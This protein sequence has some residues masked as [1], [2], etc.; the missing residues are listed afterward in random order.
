MTTLQAM[1]LLGALIGLFLLMVLFTFLYS[2]KI[3]K[4]LERVSEGERTVKTANVSKDDSFETILEKFEVPKEY[5]KIVI[6]QSQVYA[7]NNCPAVLWKEENKIKVLL[8]R[9]RPILVEEEIEDFQYITSSPY[10]NFRQFDGSYF[11]DWAAQ[12]KAIKEL[13]LPY[14]EMGVGCGGIDYDRQ[15]YWAGTM[16]VYAPSMAEIFRMLGNPLSYY[17]IHVDNVRRMKEDGSIPPD[18]LA[19]REAEKQAERAAAEAEANVVNGASESRDMDAVWEAIR[20]LENKGNDEIRA[21]DVNKLN[22]YLIKE[23]RFEDLERSTIDPEFQKKLLK[24]LA[25]K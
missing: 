15:T 24:E 13:F 22:A 2:K 14:I 17:K 8:L 5:Y 21:E 10:V 6:A 20:R 12:P 25:E 1:I 4:G 3:E 16:C 18:M 7:A 9:T 11:P 19:Q 23:K